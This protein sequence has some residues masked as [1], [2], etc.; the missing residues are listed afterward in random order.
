MPAPEVATQAI[1][2]SREIRGESFIAYQLLS[3]D[4]GLTIGLARRSQK[5]SAIP[6]IDLFD[7]GDFRIERKPGRSS[8]FIKEARISRRRSALARNYLAFKS[9]S[10][11]AKLLLSNP[12]HEENAS[13]VTEL[14]Q[15]GLDAW[16]DHSP[17]IAVYLKCL[18]LYCRHEGYPVKE[19]WAQRLPPSEKE[20]VRKALNRPLSEIEETNT[21]LAKSIQSLETYLEQHTHIRLL[22]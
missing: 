7:E 10:K 2:L 5:P 8:G 6:M 9:A 13:I 1:A 3:P 17:P 11:F 12:I 14:L 4:A 21:D 16:E 18:Y 15:K 19:Q 22:P 20:T